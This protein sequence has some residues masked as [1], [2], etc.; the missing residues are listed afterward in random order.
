MINMLNNDESIK[1]WKTCCNNRSLLEDHMLTI[2]LHTGV[3]ILSNSSFLG[4][5]VTI[6]MID[7]IKLSENSRIRNGSSLFNTHGASNRYTSTSNSQEHPSIQ[8]KNAIDHFSTAIKETLAVRGSKV[9]SDVTGIQPA[10]APRVSVLM[11]NNGRATQ[12]NNC[13]MS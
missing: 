3:K 2:E 8:F 10:A 11:I 1:N 9:C 12:I 4:G 5:G 13:P 6:T 7:G